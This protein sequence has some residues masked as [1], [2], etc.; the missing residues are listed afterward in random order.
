[1]KAIKPHLPALP[2]YPYTTAQALIK[3]DQNE[4]PYG[5][6]AELKAELA[7]RLAELPLNRYPRMHAETLAERIADF[8]GWPE[9]G[10]VVGPGSNTIIFALVA[11]A[12]NILDVQP[13]FVHYEHSAHLLGA[14]YKAVLLREG[15]E[16]P[17]EEIQQ[18]LSEGEPGVFFL[19][20]PHTPTGAF[21]ALER[22]AAIAQTAAAEEWLMVVDEAYYQFAPADM[23]RQ[24]QGELHLAI[25]RTFSKAWGL[26]GARAGYLLASDEVARVVRNLLPPFG[27]P[28]L[29]VLAVELALEHPGYVAEA[30]EKVR[31]ERDRVYLELKAHPVWDAYPSHTNFLLIRTPDA[32]AAYQGLLKRGVL[33]RRQDHIPGLEGAIRVTIGTPVENDAFLQAAFELA[34]EEWGKEK[35]PDDATGED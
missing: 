6:P 16:L 10:V 5:L 22:V 32:E 14:P 13:S 27:V 19:P 26:A 29:T 35:E 20:N 9:S 2:D 30:V 21:F 17:V 33:V 34:K 11:A 28:S 15:F 1:M 3:L 4:S 12:Q 25:L 23:K 18:A 24:A 31:R 8:E 7:S